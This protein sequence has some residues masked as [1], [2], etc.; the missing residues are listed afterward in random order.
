MCLHGEGRTK[1]VR[2]ESE[3]EKLCV[4]KEENT[5]YIYI[6]IQELH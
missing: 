3:C 4:I 6:S 2:M 1:Q 5:L